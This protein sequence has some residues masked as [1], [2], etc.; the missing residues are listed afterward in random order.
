MKKIIS[1]IALLLMFAGYSVAGN[2]IAVTVN[3][4]DSIQTHQ[5]AENI[6][7]TFR[8]TDTQIKDGDA[9][10]MIDINNNSSNGVFIFHKA[11]TEKEL[12]K[13]A[14]PYKIKFSKSFPGTKGQRN[15]IPAE[16]IGDMLVLNP[17]RS[18]EICD[19]VVYD[20]IETE[21][22]IPFYLV[23]YKKNGEYSRVKK[24]VQ[25][26][27]ITI[28][29]DIHLA[30]PR[31]YIEMN[32]Q[33]D[34][35][36]AELANITFCDNPKHSPTLEEQRQVYI[37]RID[38]IKI[39]IDSVQRD[40]GWNITATE[41]TKRRAETDICQKF[42]SLEAKLLELNVENVPLQDCG[43]HKVAAPHYCKYCSYDFQKILNKL[44]NIYMKID[45]S[46]DPD[47]L[48]KEYAS[49]VSKIVSCAKRR[50][51]YRKYQKDIEEFIERIN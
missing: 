42:L 40:N 9:R 13:K 2:T 46:D 28:E 38:A 39:R 10:V 6:S 49:D 35:L 3:E 25:M 24:I 37:D 19:A 4:A 32:E 12:K 14:Q 18:A 29:F 30:E 8:L 36:I 11:Y 21:L 47:A 48:R 22:T 45:N 16:C 15:V 20:G 5:I 17:S 7:L 43:G 34:T 51:G 31:E 33:V 50:S 44:E 23:E 26:E 41:H 1:I 27:E